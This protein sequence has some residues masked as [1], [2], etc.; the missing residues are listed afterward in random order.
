V[1]QRADGFD[2]TIRNRGER[3]VSG[4][5]VRLDLPS[6]RPLGSATTALLSA[7]STSARLLLPPIPGKTTR[8]FS[9]DYAGVK[10]ASS[11]RVAPHPRSAPRKKKRFWW[12]PW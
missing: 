7:G 1:T 3:L 10:R 4:A 9:V 8:V 12:L 5:V 6:T 11:A 2:V